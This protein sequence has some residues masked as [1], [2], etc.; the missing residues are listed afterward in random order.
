MLFLHVAGTREHTN[1]A[2]RGGRFDPVTLGRRLENARQM[3][4]LSQKD[5]S[6]EL[7]PKQSPES[8]RQAWSKMVNGS[9]RDFNLA[10]VELAVD[11]LARSLSNHPEHPELRGTKLP[12]FPFIDLRESR[13]L[14]VGRR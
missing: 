2:K 5:I 3:A 10:E 12:G 4:G 13:S 11:L 9:L 8:A 6:T 1:R 14:E 7:W